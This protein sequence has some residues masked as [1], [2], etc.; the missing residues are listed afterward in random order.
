M[1]LPTPQRPDAERGTNAIGGILCGNAGCIHLPPEDAAAIY[2]RAK[3]QQAERVAKYP[4]E[5]S[6]IRA[7]FDGYTRL[8]EMGWCD[9]SYAPTD[10]SPLQVIE[11]GS[12]GIHEATRDSERRFWIHDGDTWPSTPCLFRAPLR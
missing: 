3:R 12:T 2:E 7:M 1:T 8:K 4:D 10:G 6:A 9:A 5:E 11:V